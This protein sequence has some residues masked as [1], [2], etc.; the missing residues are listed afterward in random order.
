M[1][2]FTITRIPELHFGIG[3]IQSLPGLIAS[4]AIH[5]LALILGGKSFRQSDTYERFVKELQSL[6]IQWREFSVSGEP[7]PEVVDGI[8]S[9]LKKENADPRIEGVLAIGGGSVLD[10][11]KAVAA[12]MT[13]E[14]SV[15]DYLEGVGTRKPTGTRLPFFAVPTTA[16]TGTE[17]TK[18]AV[19]S[20]IGPNGFKKSFRHDNYVPDVALLD[21][22]LTVTCPPLVTAASGLDAITQLLEAYT[23]T[24]ANPFTDSLALGA[25][26]AAGK[27]FLPA[28][29]NGNDLEARERMSYAAYISGICLAQAG[30]GVVHGI[31]APFGGMF[32]VSHGIVCSTLVLSATKFTVARLMKMDDPSEDSALKRY[33]RA[34]KALSG[35]DADSDNG[36]V[37]LLIKTLEKFITETNLPALKELGLTQE[38][39]KK[40]AS[41]TEAKN[42]P[43]PLTVEDIEAILLDRYV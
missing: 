10:T 25:L 36:N 24:K 43:I 40:I 1:K 9:S 28:F 4:R 2:P 34:G 33:A 20:R 17:A 18:N 41:R 11:G 35:K 13:V 29:Q 38:D 42:H 37:A 7:S 22:E 39:L 31:A 6:G 16:G 3:K 23:C 26:E 14:G 15:Q 5:S 12:M 8:V 21:P 27:G 32:P 30:L 19:I